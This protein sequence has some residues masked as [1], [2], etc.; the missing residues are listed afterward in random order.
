MG[1][2]NSPREQS[3]RNAPGIALVA[4]LLAGS[5]LAVRDVARLVGGGG[6]GA[7]A[8]AGIL[9]ARMVIMGFAVGCI[10]LFLVLVHRG[11][12]RLLRRWRSTARW[13]PALLLTAL[14]WSLWRELSARVLSG[15][16][17]SQSVWAGPLSHALPWILMGGM[18]VTLRWV[19]A[20]V[21]A[22]LRG[23]L[24]RGLALGV[25]YI[26]VGFVLDAADRRFY[27]GL[28]LY[29]HD[30]L[31]AGALF[32]VAVGVGIIFAR[33]REIPRATWICL[34]LLLCAFLAD[35]SLT[36]GPRERFLLHTRTLE[37]RRIVEVWKLM[38]LDRGTARTKTLPVEEFRR[39]RKESLQR[40]AG[41]R[42]PPAASV[43]NVVWLTV[44][45]LRKDHLG[46]Y[47]YRRHPT[48]PN[49]DR[50]AKTAVVFDGAHA[51]FPI[52]SLSFQSMFY[53]RFP[54]ATPLFQAMQGRP[55][56]PPLLTLAETLRAEGIRTAGV[57]AIAGDDLKHPAYR[58]LGKGFELLP[59]S[60]ERNDISEPAQAR[61]AISYLTAL[62]SERFF[63]W[64]HL[65]GPHH[66]YV[67]R[68]HDF[69]T[70]DV[71]RYDSEIAETDLWIGRILQ[72]LAERRLEDD[73]VVI[74]NADHGEAFG[75]HASRFH[76]TTLYEEQIG[77]P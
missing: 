18:A 44:D 67:V 19:A 49:L 54:S 58:V 57:P 53:G 24:A 72:A 28:Y 25:A 56:D 65:M 32:A 42:R 30:G 23:G 71:D 21:Q 16:A 37:G 27:P 20:H 73:T 45:T 7:V 3:L 8:A 10:L 22:S 35:R 66:P 36:L 63:L 60:V 55:L 70:S 77:V 50:F 26:L 12:F 69:G 39:A 13:A 33:L 61:R 6:E 52:T 1:R 64:V 9:L 51:Q 75:E 68:G 34:L 74:I 15:P 46:C 38:G 29:L 14:S 47:G 17:V 62:A 2:M 5:A 41:A 43:R 76:G 40:S 4:G 11:A 48:S 59:S 31:A